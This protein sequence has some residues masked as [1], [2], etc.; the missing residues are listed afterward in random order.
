MNLNGFSHSSLTIDHGKQNLLLEPEDVN[1]QT[2]EGS[3]IEEK[4]ITETLGGWVRVLNQSLSELDFFHYENS[5]EKGIITRIALYI[6]PE[7][8]AHIRKTYLCLS[9]KKG[10]ADRLKNLLAEHYKKEAM[11]ERNTIYSGIGEVSFFLER[12]YQDFTLQGSKEEFN[13]FLTI[14]SNVALIGDDAIPG[15]VEKQL[16]GKLGFSLKSDSSIF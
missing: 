12:T 8:F 11:V 4:K 15:D 14:I 6:C 10:H 2:D 13:T 7:A 3:I 9:C 5:T 16:K 1:Q